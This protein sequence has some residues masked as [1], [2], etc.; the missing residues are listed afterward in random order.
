[1]RRLV[2]PGQGIQLVREDVDAT[3]TRQGDWALVREATS[4]AVTC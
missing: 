2:V 1:M 4:P 3:S